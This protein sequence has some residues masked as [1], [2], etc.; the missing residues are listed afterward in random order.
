MALSQAAPALAFF[1]G[2]S[3]LDS[4][5]KPS[6]LLFSGSIGSQSYLFEVTFPPRKSTT[7][8]VPRKSLSLTPKCST[9]SP[10]DV[11]EDSEGAS[12]QTKVP[13]GYTRKDVLLIGLGVTVVGVL[14]KNGLEFFGVDSLK[15]GNVVQL[16]LVLGLTVGWIGTYIFR[17][18]NKDMTY[19]Q[20][21]RDYEN[22]VMQKRLEGLTEAEIEVLLEQVD[23]EKQRLAASEQ[24]K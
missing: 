18:S 20:Q 12:E 7:A 23:E 14:L 4:R 8:C 9:S 17:V 10:D 2:S 15:A 19:A 16:V 21:L 24:L 1:H 5:V 13:F 11:K 22:K 6:L 3:Y